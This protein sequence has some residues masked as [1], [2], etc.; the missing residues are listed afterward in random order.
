MTTN[1]LLRDLDLHEPIAAD[2]RRLEV[3]VDGLP[4][5]G[6]AQLALD[7][8]LVSA[9]HC[10]GT[11]RRGAA[12]NEGV[13]TSMAERR[14]DLSS[15]KPD[16]VWWCWPLKSEAG[17]LQSRFISALAHARAW[18]ER[19]LLRRRVEHAW[20]LRWGALLS[21]TAARAVADAFLELPRSVGADGD[22]LAT[23][24][25]ERGFVFAGLAR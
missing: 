25:V 6:G 10:D 7:T 23:H 16:L 20:R 14:K 21:C 4:L 22:T 1:V 18:C 24:E 11:A 13:A 8:T 9:L 12:L 17:G 19:W 15:D 2:G 3:A 5:F